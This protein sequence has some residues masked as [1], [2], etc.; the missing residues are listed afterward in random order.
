MVEKITP[1]NQDIRIRIKKSPIYSYM[2]ADRLGVSTDSFYRMLR[3]ALTADAK[4]KIMDAISA[5]EKEA[6]AA[7]D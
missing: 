6:V 3:G 7:H 5:T 2:V 1:A 4:Q